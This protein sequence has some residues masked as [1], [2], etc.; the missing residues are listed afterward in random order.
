[1][2]FLLTKSGICACRGV[3]VTCRLIMC[4]SPSATPARLLI[5]DALVCV[6]SRNK[7]RAK[8]MQYHVL[9]LIHVLHRTFGDLYMF[10]IPISIAARVLHHIQYTIKGRCV[11]LHGSKY[12][13]SCFNNLNTNA[14]LGE[15]HCWQVVITIPRS[16]SLRPHLLPSLFVLR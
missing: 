5:S 14:R 6:E 4:P 12:F 8:I 1:M 11:S 16:C 9:K 13:D 10:V 15:V 3:I 7:L 2:F